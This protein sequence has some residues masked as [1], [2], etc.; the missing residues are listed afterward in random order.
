MYCLDTNMVI[1]FQKNVPS[2][3]QRIIAT[4]PSDISITNITRAELFYGA[5]KSARIE[6]NLAI[7]SEFCNSIQVLLPHTESDKIFGALKT[8]TRSSRQVV[9]DMDLL[10]ASICISYGC[11]LVTN[12][13]RDFETIHGLRIE[14]WSR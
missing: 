9:A 1:F 3:V 2:V 10:I 14:D 5:M 8:H 6:E 11:T 12:N 7:Q 13:I 4:N